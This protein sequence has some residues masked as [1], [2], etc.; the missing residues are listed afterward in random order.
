MILEIS[1]DKV[2]IG[3]E[4]PQSVKILRNE[5]AETI[6]ANQEAVTAKVPENIEILRSRMK[7]K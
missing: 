7:N 1:G 3:I 2:K 4:A 5:V 6:A